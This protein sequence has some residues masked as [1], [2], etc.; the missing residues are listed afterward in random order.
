M[1]AR[2][3]EA[4]RTAGGKL[5]LFGV[6]PPVRVQLER[7]GLLAAIGEVNVFP[8]EPVIGAPLQAARAAAESW[9][10]TAGTPVKPE[11]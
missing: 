8:T 4:L 7:T 9:L 3:A 11:G 1:L 5:M 6:N 10:R 2:Y